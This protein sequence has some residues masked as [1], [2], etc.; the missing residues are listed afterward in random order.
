MKIIP[1]CLLI[2][3]TYD[4]I[5]KVLYILGGEK[6]MKL[7]NKLCVSALAAAMIITAALGVWALP[8]D[9]VF[10]ISDMATGNVTEEAQYGAFT[11]IPATD[12]DGASKPLVVDGSKKTG[13]TTGIK[14]TK[15]LKTGA[16]GDYSN[17]A[18]RFTTEAETVLYI[19]CSSANSSDS[20][21]GKII[22]SQ[23][24]VIEAKD[25]APGL[26][27]YK[28][29]I[30][31]AGD[32]AFVSEGG[33]INI[34]YMN[35]SYTIPEPDP[36]FENLEGVVM[37]PMEEIYTAP[38]APADGKGTAEEPMSVASAVLNIAP[39]GTIHCDGRYMF[40]DCL[41][42]DLN[43]SGEEGKEK[44]IDCADGTVFDFSYEPYSGNGSARGVQIDGNYWYI[45]GLE[46]Y[47]AADNGF[48]IAG[49][50]NTLELCV[51]NANRDT[52]IQVSR[53]AS[54][55]SDYNDWPSDNLLLNCTSFNN[56][57][58][59]TGENADGF[60]A[61]L[62]CGAGNVFDGCIAYNNCDDGW[63]CF[64]KS[65]TG[66]IGTLVMR[67]CVAFRSG[68][69]TDGQFT[70]NCDGNGFK[71]GGSKIAVDHYL[72]NC[73]A[74]E[75][76]N[77]GFTDNS[78]PGHIYLTNCTS[79]NNALDGGSKKSNFDFARDSA[80]SNN[81]LENCLSYTDNKIASDKFRGT[82][83]NSALYNNKPMY[84]YYKEFPF[85][86]W[87]DK[88]GVTLPTEE[89]SAPDP[90]IFVSVEA[91]PPGADVHRLWRNEDGSV[92]MGTFLK[93][94]DGTAYKELNIGANLSGEPVVFPTPEPVPTAAPAPTTDPD[95]TPAPLEDYVLLAAENDL[96]ENIVDISF[97]NN[98]EADVT[99]HIIVALYK[100]V[101]GTDLVVN[102]DEQ[103]CTAS[104]NSFVEFSSIIEETGYDKIKVFAWDDTQNI[105]PFTKCVE[106]IPT[107]Y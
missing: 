77:H 64:T 40:N 98:T 99:A 79:F 80:P 100:T 85:T 58:P 96:D 42:I 37:S 11:I 83:N 52:G 31:E 3:F 4:G 74:F 33:G 56:F 12:A 90:S 30:P 19:D 76:A 95:A 69:T 59:A 61:K 73:V 9:S 21:T 23:N 91:P 51:A 32:Y 75:N 97:A 66:P 41:L 65:A 71:M 10:N 101:D 84:Y 25:I 16:D 35:L 38:Y 63:D 34:Y 72:Y 102:Y 26:A 54:T 57:D 24:N 28:Y 93:V 27:Y 50:H 8:E 62:T 6:T 67:N 7:I 68:Q 1:I 105:M 60:A 45:K 86:Y 22:D 89:M 49:K 46:V 70:E 2:I 106:I 47:M 15:R 53:R 29:Y 36:D 20:R 44:R 78:N 5:I 48:F 55:V 107:Q 17:R 18:I 39:G 92:N 81:T 94:A 87:N 104:K 88:E 82:V 103:E 13:A 14:Y 43:N